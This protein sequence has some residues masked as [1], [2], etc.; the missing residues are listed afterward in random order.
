VDAIREKFED[1]LLLRWVAA[2]M[3]G[4]T[5]GLIAGGYLVRLPS[6]PTICFPLL[7]LIGGFAGACAGG[8]QWYI[9]REPYDLPPRWI[10][11]SFVGAAL[12]TLPA[13]FVGVFLFLASMGAS[14]LGSFAAIVMGALIGGGVGSGQAFVLQNRLSDSARWWIAACAAGGGVCGLLSLMPILP[15]LPIGILTGTALY[16][17]I[18]GRTLLWLSPPESL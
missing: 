16:G 18:T 12:A 5:V 6:L 1:S 13:Y 3:V 7:C 9:L 4:W 15:P 17:Y 11:M 14:V 10:L 8:I 2:N